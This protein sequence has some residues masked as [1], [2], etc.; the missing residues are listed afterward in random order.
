L[1]TIFK[2]YAALNLIDDKGA[3]KFYE[4]PNSMFTPQ[5]LERSGAR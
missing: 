2:D 4:R 3:V 1:S 5:S